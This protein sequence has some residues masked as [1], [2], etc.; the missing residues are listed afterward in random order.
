MVRLTSVLSTP[1]GRCHH[2]HT[3]V[4]AAMTTTDSQ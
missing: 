1:S 4:T 3:V 2:G